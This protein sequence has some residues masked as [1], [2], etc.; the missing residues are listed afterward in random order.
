MSSYVGR[1]WKIWKKLRFAQQQ[2]EELAR[3]KPVTE[4]DLS[5]RKYFPFDRAALLIY[6]LGFWLAPSWWFIDTRKRQRTA[7][8]EEKESAIYVTIW[9]L[10]LT[11]AWLWAPSDGTAAT[12][13][14]C[15]ALFRFVE[16]A[17]AILGFVLDQREP[18]I[19]R[20]LVTI[21][22]LALQ[23]ALIFSILDHSFA[24]DDFL[25]PEVLTMG[26]AGVHAAGSP[27]EYLYLSWTYMTT[28]GNPYTPGSEL[29]RILQL[30]A[31]TSGILLL[32]IVA[33]RAIGLVGDTKTIATDLE[34]RVGA[35]EEKD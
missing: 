22:I 7:E 17:V 16:I 28:L 2:E 25:K 30:G 32:S 21:A 31:T 19:A 12:I 33:A 23:V 3:S 15:L 9:F 8:E 11:A 26:Q 29:A 34:E 27:L 13:L 18:K 20:S 14:G 6:R 35:L 5:P 10:V 24:R 4:E 1:R